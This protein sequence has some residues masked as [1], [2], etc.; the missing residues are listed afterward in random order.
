MLFTIGIFPWFMIAATA[1]FFRPDWPIRLFTWE[2]EEEQA[3]PSLMPSPFWQQTT[4]LLLGIYFALQLLMPLRHHLYASNVNWSEE[5]HRFSWRMKLRSKSSSAQF[6]ATDP[7]N[8]VTWEIE[9]EDYLTERQETRM[10]S[11]PD[12]ILQFAHHAHDITHVL[13]L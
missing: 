3:T 11:R 13:L 10:S 1:L 2:K 6:W 8:Q 4:L 9:A 7:V 5:G 12:M